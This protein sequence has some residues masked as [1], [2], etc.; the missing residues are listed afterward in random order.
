MAASAI[1]MLVAVHIWC[2][3][4]AV[5]RVRHPCS[6]TSTYPEYVSLFAEE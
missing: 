6:D 2:T 1:K 4:F 5:T 3:R